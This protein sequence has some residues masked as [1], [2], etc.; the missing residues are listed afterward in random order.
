LLDAFL[1]LR[2]RLAALAAARGTQTLARLRLRHIVLLSKAW[3]K[4]REWEASRAVRFVEKFKIR[5]L[6]DWLWSIYRCLDTSFWIAKM[7]RYAFYD[8][9]F[10][11]LLIGWYLAAGEL[12]CAVYRE[13]TPVTDADAENIVSR[14]E[15]LPE[16]E[17]P[18]AADLPENARAAA[19]VSRKDILFK[20][21][22]LEWREAGT[23]YERLIG[24]IAR[25]Y[26]PLSENPLY[27]ARISRLLAGAARFA[28]AVGS[29]RNHPP[30][31]KTLNL[32]VRHVLW[33]KDA[34]DSLANNP[35]AA[36][37][38]KYRL[39]KI[40]KASS[41]VYKTIRKRSPAVLLK[42]IVFSLL[43]EGAKR[44]LCLF[45]HAKIAREANAVYQED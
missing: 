13:K 7:L 25:L 44:W 42:D 37:L 18:A 33:A 19:A 10:R 27:E 35:L 31:D 28:E 36:W 20:W 22:E 26:H 5:V 40:L 2:K 11:I 8:L 21:R 3:K 14:L 30:I 39:G 6:A 24:D 16:P 4:K 43:K 17:E 45:L 34:A 12:A 1:D 32:R 9:A 15:D 23:T 38:K 41:L 29:L